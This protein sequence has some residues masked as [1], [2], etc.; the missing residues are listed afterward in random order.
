MANE[1]IRPAALPV[2]T[3]PVATEVT[4][5]DDGSTVAGV[6]WEDGVNAAVP[7][8]SQSEALAGVN[9]Y[10]RMTPLTTKQAISSAQ[11]SV[12]ISAG[13]GLSGGGDLSQSRTISL[14]ENIDYG[15]L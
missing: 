14:S 3:N 11:S 4:V 10:K 5:S 13:N 6:T 7:V 1:I 8:A 9:N 15:V 2:R 12:T